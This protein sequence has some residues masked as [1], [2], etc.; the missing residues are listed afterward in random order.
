MGT[1]TFQRSFVG[2]EL[3]PALGARADLAKYIT[4]LKTCRNFLVRRHGGVSNRP[5]TRFINPTKTSSPSTFLLRYVSENI[6]E[7]VLIEAGPNY[8]RIYMNGALLEVDDVDPWDAGTIYEIGD[9]A[10]SG[11]VNYYAVKKHQNEPVADPVFWSA[12]PGD[13]LEIPTPFGTD[14]FKWVQSSNVITMTSLD[15]PPQ[16]LIRLGP[17]TWRLQPVDTQ[18]AVD[19]PSAPT[20]VAGTAGTLKY[21]YYVTSVSEAGEESTPSPITLL[22][23]TAPGTDVAPIFL[24]WAI[25]TSLPAP[26]SYRV[27]KDPA[28]NG[29]FGFIGET[30]ESGQF[31]SWGGGPPATGSWFYDVGMPVDFA[32]TPPIPNVLF[33]TAGDYPKRAG[34][35]QQRR[36]F[37]HTRNEP[38]VVWGSRTGFPSNFTISSPLQDDDA[39]TFRIAGNNNNPVEHLIGLKT[40]IVMTGAGEWT[41]GEPK[42]PLSPGNIPADQETYVGAGEV[43]PVIVGNAVIYLQS[44]GAI[45]HD[46]QFEQQVEGL[47]GKDLTLFAAHLFDGFGIN[48]M[49]YQQTP[50]STVWACRSD[51]VLLGLTYLREQDVWG[52]HRHDTQASGLFEDVCVVP[53]AGEDAVYVMVRRTIGGVF[54]R[55]IEKLER[56]EIFNWA[57]DS[58]FMDSGLTYSGAPVDNIGGLGHL[59]GELVS[60]LADGRVIFNGDPE[61]DEAEDFRVTGGTIAAVIDPPA[62]IIHAGLP[63]EYAEVE[64]LDLDVS[65]AD[66]RDKEKRTGELALL[67]ERSSRV[68][69]AGPD[70]DHLVQVKLEPYETG[71]EQQ[72]FT[73]QENINV[74]TSYTKYGRVFIRQKDPLPITI[75]GV[76][77]NSELGG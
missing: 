17:T 73:G 6:G 37:A 41:V 71:L 13:V 2:G 1:S 75:L 3:A 14:G 57:A 7:S 32:V 77:P 26:A 50:H 19:A 43:R 31:K 34:Y 9:I 4:G 45:I 63:I 18:P 74:I 55:Y 69:W 5:G 60:V 53:E 70:Q 35:Y 16:E 51:G 47:G 10:E 68:F 58:F 42:V 29:T 52:W 30:T 72:S 66:V 56:R 8:L 38:D 27:Y 67:L 61:A 21:A 44:R 64:T 46:L 33:T 12:M 49:D 48:A 20:A 76:L 25:P 24:Q 23:L 65:E 28:N 54:V 40:L 22:D 11:G 15:V 39:I 62:S 36:L 59:E